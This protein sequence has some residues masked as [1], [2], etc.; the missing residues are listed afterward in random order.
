MIYLP[1]KIGL[2][3]ANLANDRGLDQG[4]LIYAVLRKFAEE[5]G[6]TC[7]HPSFAHVLHK[8]GNK[9][10]RCDLCGYLFYKKINKKIENGQIVEKAELVPRIEE[11]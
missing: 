3:Y 7:D 9:L 2:W 11:I 8:K 6:F 4:E 1:K 10:Y 5:Q